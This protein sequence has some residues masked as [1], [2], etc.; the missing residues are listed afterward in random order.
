[1]IEEKVVDKQ[2]AISPGC[3]DYCTGSG[4]HIGVCVREA[5]TTAA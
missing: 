4:L 5:Q 2:L 1:M 3:D